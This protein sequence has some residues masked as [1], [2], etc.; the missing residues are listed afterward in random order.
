MANL[1]I[2]AETVSYVISL[3]R[4][5]E[6][7]LPEA[8]ADDGENH[9]GEAADPEL[10]TEHEYDTLYQELR[11]FLETLSDEEL[12]ALTAILWIGRGTYDADD[13]DAAYAEASS[14]D[15]SRAPSYLLSSE[16]LAEYLSEGMSALGVDLEEF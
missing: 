2:S 3:A 4:D 10:I 12:A 9:R 5:I 13:F 8:N 11:G 6:N 7:A 1:P 15:A 16:L 14:L